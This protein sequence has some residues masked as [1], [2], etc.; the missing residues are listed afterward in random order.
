MPRRRKRRRRRKNQRRNRILIRILIAVLIAAAVIGA[1]LFIRGKIAG[2]YTETGE[3]FEE[4]ASASENPSEG[5]YLILDHE[6]TDG[7]CLVHSGEA[8]ISLDVLQESLNERFYWDENELLLVYTTATTVYQAE[9]ATSTYY[10]DNS[11]SD[12]G[13]TIVR[14][15]SDVVYVNLEF[16]KLF[17]DIEYTVYDDPSRIVVTS[18]WEDVSVADTKKKTRLMKTS[19]IMQGY[20]E[21]LDKD[22]TLTVLEEGTKWTKVATADGMI[23]YVKNSAISDVYT[24]SSER[25]FEETVYTNVRRDESINL[26]WNQVSVYAA[27]SYIS[28][29][30]EEADGIN[31]I[32]P[33][34]I[35]LSDD[36][37]GVESRCSTDYVTAAHKAG[38]EVWA[39]VSNLEDDDLTVEDT[40]TV[41]TNTTSRV[42]LENKLIALAIEY[43]L[44]GLNIDFETMESAVG[45]S[46]IQFIR[47]LSILCRRNNLV[48]SVDVP[49]SLGTTEY[50]AREELSEIVDYVILMAYD[51]HYSGSAAGSVASIDWVTESVVTALEEVDPEALILGIPLYT[52]LWQLSSDGTEVVGSSAYGMDAIESLLSEMGVTASWDESAGQYYAEYESDGYLYEVWL[53]NADSISLKLEVMQDNQLAGCATWRVGYESDDIWDIISAALDQ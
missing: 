8:F 29:Y 19:G 16:V 34:W 5:I 20:L 22:E 32:C 18:V 31:V 13:Y 17:T 26:T 45:D 12:A 15:E 41:L 53:E 10:V 51:E 7:D 42:A 47:E 1:G 6:I 11:Q 43:N 33:T 25:S 23:G 30:L 52:R 38:V 36:Q 50:Y 44:D 46:F 21:K 2:K 28:T 49:P 39:L 4:A 24:Q 40:T 27:N 37:G 14:I 48:L 35:N 3:W 9:S